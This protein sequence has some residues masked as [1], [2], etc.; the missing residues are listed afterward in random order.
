[1]PGDALLSSG[2]ED[3]IPEGRTDPVAGL[4]ILIVMAQVILFQPRADTS[5]H[6]KVMC[7]VMD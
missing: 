4:I 5:L 3:V 7:S 1:M 2:P 6:G